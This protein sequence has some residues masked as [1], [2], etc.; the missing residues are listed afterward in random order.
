MENQNE[1]E[2]WNERWLQQIALWR[3][4]LLGLLGQAKTLEA[5]IDLAKSQIK[6]HPPE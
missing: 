6:Q 4:E 2:D 3:A 5:L 1:R